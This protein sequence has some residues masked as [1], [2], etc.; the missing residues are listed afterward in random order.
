MGKKSVEIAYPS[1]GIEEW[2]DCVRAMEEKSGE[3][4]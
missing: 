1:Q 3:T 2:G 4:A